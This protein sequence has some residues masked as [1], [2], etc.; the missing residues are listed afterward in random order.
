MRASPP[1]PA[2]VNVT[3]PAPVPLAPAVTVIHASFAT[4]VHSQDTRLL[5]TPTLPS[6]PA[7]GTTA[8]GA[9][10]PMVQAAADCSTV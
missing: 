9:S 2:T 3:E 1:L 7:A 4:A 5:V 8:P 10:S 6:P